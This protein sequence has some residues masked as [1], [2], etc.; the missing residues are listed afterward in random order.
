VDWELKNFHGHEY[1]TN[2]GSSYNSYLIRD[3]KTVLIDTVWLPYDKEFVANLKRE[4]DLKEIDYIIANHSEVDHSGALVELMA[5]IPDTPIYCT[6]NGVKIL[7][8][9]YHQDWNFV[10]VKTGDT[11]N[12]G[13][14]TLT[15]VEAPMLHWPDSMMTYMSGENILFSNDAF[16]QHYATESLYNDNVDNCEL[17][18]EALKYYA[19]ILTPFSR[20]VTKKI[21]EVL[22]FNLPVNL[23]CTSHG[24][25]WKHE[26]TQI[27]EK[28]LKWANDY[29]EDQITII[30]DTMWNSTRI[31]GEAIAKGIMQADSKLTVKLFNAAKEDKNDLITEIFKSKAILVGSPTINNGFLHSIAGL[32]EMAKGMKFKNKKAAAFGSYGWSGEVVKQLTERLK[33]AGFEVVNDGIRS[34]W[35]PDMDEMDSLTNYGK[36]F[37][38]SI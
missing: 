30:Y 24:V 22:S 7:K 17:Y 27:I 26:P 6:A 37:V 31:M 36:A 21:E 3:E 13:S 29:Q 38:E 15:F 8:G 20:L 16:G 2:K 23:I 19:N 25:I 12:I 11:L 14:S 4:I 32:L 5:E 33:D 9:H 1:S 34:L 28:Y 10:T 35:V 18:A